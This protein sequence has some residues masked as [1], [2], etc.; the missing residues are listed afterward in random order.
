[1]DNSKDVK[2]LWWLIVVLGLFGLGYTYYP[3]PP[4]R[5][6]MC[7]HVLEQLLKSPSSLQPVE[8]ND[9]QRT[10]QSKF[11]IDPHPN[12]TWWVYIKYDAQ[13]GFGAV[14]RG[15]ASCYFDDADE[16]L[17]MTMNGK[18]VEE[19]YLNLYKL[20]LRDD[21]DPPSV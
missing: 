9:L 15:S 11:T 18:D 20:G 7:F 4:E 3:K 2:E 19:L 6:R 17:E 10:S 8:I 21:Y 5:V 16:L 14:V 1:M 12:S 13:N